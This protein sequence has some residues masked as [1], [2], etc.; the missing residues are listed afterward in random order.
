MRTPNAERDARA[1]MDAVPARGSISVNALRLQ[2]RT[3]AR[4]AF[5]AELRHLVADERISLNTGRV[6]RITVDQVEWAKKRE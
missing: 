3:L 2:C 1:I 4:A 6:R 5:V